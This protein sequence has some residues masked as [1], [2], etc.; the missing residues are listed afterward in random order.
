MIRRHLFSSSFEGVQGHYQMPQQADSA[1]TNSHLTHVLAEQQPVPD[2]AM[3]PAS[4]AGASSV[5][6]G[7]DCTSGDAD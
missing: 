1:L 7:D 4:A 3:H 5:D 2:R 6:V